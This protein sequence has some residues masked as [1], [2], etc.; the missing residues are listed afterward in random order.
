MGP[1]EIDEE[2]DICQH[3]SIEVFEIPAQDD[4]MYRGAK[5]CGGWIAAGTTVHIALICN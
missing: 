5:R 4:D 2:R 3:G 1:G